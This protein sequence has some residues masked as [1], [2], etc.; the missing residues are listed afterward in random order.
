VLELRI[1]ISKE[2]EAL[3]KLSEPEFREDEANVDIVLHEDN[4][5]GIELCDEGQEASQLSHQPATA[6]VKYAFQPT[7]QAE[8]VSIEAPDDSA[9]SLADLMSKLK[10]L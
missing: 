6:G 1:Q 7:A 3:R 9:D 2:K 8:S 5:F 10:N 4:E